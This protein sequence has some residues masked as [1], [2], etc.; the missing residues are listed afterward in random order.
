MLEVVSHT[1][2]LG[3]GKRLSDCKTLAE[4]TEYTRRYERVLREGKTDNLWLRC[5]HCRDKFDA[6][7]Q[8]GLFLV[9]N[10]SDD[11][12][13]APAGVVDCPNPKCSRQFKAEA[14]AGWRWE[15]WP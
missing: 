7:A 14:P 3:R 5:P 1:T 6:P 9:P 10:R 13:A 4:V 15:L 12:T 2:P 8:D 11:E